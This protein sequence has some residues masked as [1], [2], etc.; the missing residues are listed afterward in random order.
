[1]VF[2]SPE[3]R[4]SRSSGTSIRL[5]GF[6]IGAAR[7]ETP[8]NSAGRISGAAAAEGLA[9]FVTPSSLTMMPYADHGFRR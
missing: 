1:M 2:P 4:R 9:R 8:D 3:E 7:A 6:G 5:G